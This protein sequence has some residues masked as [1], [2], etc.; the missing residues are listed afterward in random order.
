MTLTLTCPTS[1]I[2]KHVIRL[3]GTSVLTLHQGYSAHGAALTQPAHETMVDGPLIPISRSPLPLSPLAL[4]PIPLSLNES[5]LPYLP[6]LHSDQPIPLHDLLARLQ[7]LQ[8][9]PSAAVQPT[10]WWLY[11]LLGVGFLLVAVGVGVSHGYMLHSVRHRFQKAWPFVS[12]RRSQ[13]QDLQERG[14]CGNPGSTTSPPTT[15]PPILDETEDEDMS[16]WS[17]EELRGRGK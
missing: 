4:T 1:P 13:G 17:A 10:H 6:Y 7:T 9:P 11:I 3:S 14:L 8:P 15:L 12:S 5:N 2:H 16:C